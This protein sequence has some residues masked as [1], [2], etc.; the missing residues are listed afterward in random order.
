MKPS[1][2][3]ET[4]ATV[5]G[6]GVTEVRTVMK[7]L[8]AAGLRRGGQGSNPPDI[9]AQE[10][11][12]TLL[13]LMIVRPKK[14]VNAADDVAAIEKFRSGP[15]FVVTSKGSLDALPELVGFSAD[16]LEHWNL[17]E[18]LERVV[19][20]IGKVDEISTFIGLE[21]SAGWPVTLQID[22]PGFT[23]EIEFTGVLDKVAVGDM[24]RLARVGMATLKFI[25][26]VTREA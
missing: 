7:T 10:A 6:A 20:H 4:F 15:D 13:A 16:D 25:G 8:L 21:A 11:I 3:A 19:R 26:D 22:G 23:G 17:L 9:S 2:F 5:L 1:M 14:L 24:Q 18:V 12:R